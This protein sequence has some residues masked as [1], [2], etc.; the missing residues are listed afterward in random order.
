MEL[1]LTPI[2][3][4]VGGG[5][6]IWS[7]KLPSVLLT[8]TNVI[9]LAAFTGLGR[10]FHSLG[11]LTAKE[12]SYCQKTFVSYGNNKTSKIYIEKLVFNKY[13]KLAISN[14]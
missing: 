1:L 7:A 4:L 10:Q 13:T 3:P 9:V 14:S 11:A 2:Q 8:A 12:F 5:S 6:G